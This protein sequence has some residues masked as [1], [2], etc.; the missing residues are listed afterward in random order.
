VALDGRRIS[1][2]D[3][4]GHVVILAFWA[5]WCAPC[6]DELPLLSKY[7]SQ[8]ADAGLSVLGFCLDTPDKVGDVRQVAQGLSFPVGLMPPSTAPGYG[9]IWRLPVSFTIDRAGKLVDDGWKDKPPAL[10]PERLEK[11]VTPLL[12]P[13]ARPTGDIN[14]QTA[15]NEASL[16]RALQSRAIAIPA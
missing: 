9:R 15:P 3:L 8:H 13:M 6:R 2:A 7:A 16:S 4:I 5:T 1:T 10:T 11:I 12:S 14:G